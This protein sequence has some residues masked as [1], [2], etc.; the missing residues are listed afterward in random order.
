VRLWDHD[1]P[2]TST[3][4]VKRREVVAELERLERAAGN[5]RPA[6][7]GAGGDAWV[8]ELIGRVA[9]RS[10]GDVRPEVRLDALGF[11]SLMVTELAVALEEAGVE[12]PETTEG[13]ETVND[14]ETVADVIRFASA[15]RTE[16]RL[17]RKK[18][19]IERRSDDEIE[20]PAAI[21]KAG[22]EVLGFGQ[23]MLYSR[24][25]DSKVTGKAYVPPF[26]GYIIAANHASHLDMGLVKHALGENGDKLVALA[27]KDYFFEDPIRKAYFENFTNLVPME[28]HGSLRES[29]RLAVEVIQDGYILL[30]FPE[31]T[32]SVTGVMTDFKPS[33]GYLAMRSRC[34]I[35]PMF[36]AGTHEALPKGGWWLSSRDVGAHAGPFLDNDRLAA[37]TASMGR[38]QSYRAIANHCEGVVRRL[39]PE[40]QTWALGEPGRATVADYT[41]SLDEQT[42]TT[43]AGAPQ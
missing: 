34:G 32:R 4:K 18:V 41:A 36:L 38:A 39:C 29:L 17:R 6:A 11:D 8:R 27:A 30:I 42:H 1:L 16:R 37:M 15:R 19:I 26:G 7:N 23:R 2:K 9:Q 12:L 28:R 33:L 22:R 40:E 3:R 31:G 14:L 5:V 35:L 10:S 20:V 24:L 25:L 43:P 21:A 13:S